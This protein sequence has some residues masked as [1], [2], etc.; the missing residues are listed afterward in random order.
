MDG[1]GLIELVVNV[2][3]CAGIDAKHGIVGNLRGEGEPKI[4]ISR[5]VS[6]FSFLWISRSK[7]ASSPP[8]QSPFF[9]LFYEETAV[10]AATAQSTA[11]SRFFGRIELDYI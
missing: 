1:C 10:E 2:R 7:F 5:L 9:C 6:K 3:G 4:K 8:V 11:R